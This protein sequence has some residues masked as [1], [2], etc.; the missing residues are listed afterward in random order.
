MSQ[1]GRKNIRRLDDPELSIDTVGGK[2]INLSIMTREGFR[3][4]PAFAI[5]VDA[6]HSFIEEA[7]LY[8]RIGDELALIDYDDGASVREGADRIRSMIAAEDMPQSIVDEIRGFMAEYGGSYF[9]VRS[10]AVAEDLPDAS[11]AGQQDTFLFIKPEDVPRMA[12]MCWASYWNDRAVKYRHDMGIDHLSTGMAVVVQRMVSSDTSGV[13]F[14]VN[15]VDGSDDFVIESSWGLGE[16]IASGI[17]TP[18]RFVLGRDG[19]VRDREIRRK[20]R[21]YFLVDGANRLMDIE[22]ERWDV[23]SSDEGVLMKVLDLGIRLETAFGAPQDVEWAVE[24]GTLYVLQS[25]NI[26]TVPDQS[27]YDDVLWTR[28]YGDEYWADAT[29]PMF[30]DVMG[31]MLT[32]YVNHEGARMMGYKD[33]ASGELIRLHKSRAYFNAH[34]LERVFSYYPRFVRSKELLNYFPQK[35]QKRISELP[36]HMG[37]AVWSQVRVLFLDHDG[38]ILLT[39]RAYRKWAA[40]FM[41]VCREFDSTDLEGLDDAELVDLYRRV[42]AASI[43][44]Y[45]LIRYGMVSHSIATNLMVKNWLKEW[46]GDRDG[47]C[48]AGLMSGLEN[49]RT[50][51]TNIAFSDMARTVRGDPDLKRRIDSMSSEEFVKWLES[52]SIPF[53]TQFDDFID[54]YGHRSNTRGIYYPRWRENKPYVIDV[55]RLLSQSDSDLGRLE[56]ER[57]AERL[58]LEKDVRRRIRR[59]SPVGFMRCGLYGAVLRLA[60]RYLTFRENQRFY[61]DHI[62]FRER[63]AILDMGRRL[64]ER[65]AIASADD[66]FFLFE[67]EALDMLLSGSDAPGDI[68]ARKAE[69]F[70]YGSI[71]PPKFLRNGVDFD[72]P[73]E[74]GSSDSIRGTAS[75]PGVVTGRVRIVESIDGLSEIRDGDILVTSNTDP[76]WTAAFS[77]LGGLVTETGGILSHGAV[78]S[79]EYRIPAVTAVTGATEMF[80]TGQRITVDGNEGII[81]LEDEE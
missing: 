53:R 58:E 9:A 41:E 57:R 56:E 33:L 8:D 17:I 60:Q 16:S 1:S 79:R 27:D 68:D 74:S 67:K 66:V 24:G 48:Y 54:A 43:K 70:K 62:L 45:R 34:T 39:D 14:T 20:E 50:V 44:H 32:E 35:D 5:T 49:N 52:Q 73:P 31:K 22:P 36:A 69:F 4:P 75:S 12:V 11:F 2:A 65:G 72:D 26:T 78:I 71:L 25:R 28:G 59:S 23:P 7:G 19:T 77:R 64:A 55:V 42:E 80:K 21:G 76:G 38:C 6:Y 10:S 15:P 47:A 63:L 37:K 40:G 81:Y 29:S 51:E 30:F 61:L 3:V 13:M 18:D 46:I